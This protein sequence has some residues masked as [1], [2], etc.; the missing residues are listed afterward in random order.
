MK[1]TLT[2]IA[3]ASMVLGMTIPAAF[4]STSSPS[5][6]QRTISIGSYSVG[7][8]GIAAT[9]PWTGHATEFM[10]VWYLQQ[11]LKA[12]GYKATWDGTNHTLKITTPDESI[13]GLPPVTAISGDTTI[14]IN[15]VAVVNAPN[16]LVAK[17]PASGHLTSY[18]PIFYFTKALKMVG[19]HSNYNGS[20]GS[21]TMTAPEKLAVTGAKSVGVGQSD[22]L[23]LTQNGTAV[24]SGVTWSTTGGAIDQSGNFIASA[25]GTYTVTASYAGQTA[26]MTVAVHVTPASVSL[27]TKSNSVVGNGASTDI[28]TATVDDASNNAVS[29]YTGTVD[30]TVPSGVTRYRVTTKLLVQEMRYRLM[31]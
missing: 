12:L 5:Y 25:A 13:T 21:W 14:Y 19:F 24:T 23:G 30:I 10:P 3:A 16:Q 9:D 29:N 20:A 8:K 7:A 15:G 31:S 2:G 27:T 17:D 18:L 6:N 4:A 28:V 11:G 1:R 22:T 26:T